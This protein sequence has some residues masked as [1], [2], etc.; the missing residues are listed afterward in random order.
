MALAL[1]QLYARSGWRA[2]AVFSGGNPSGIAPA[3]LVITRQ[4]GG[5]CAVSVLAARTIDGTALELVLSERL[6]SRVIYVL[7]WS[8]SSTP[9]SFV[10]PLAQDPSVQSP[11]DDPDAEAN[12]VDLAWISND[13][14]PSG[15]CDRRSGVACVQYD[16]L[17]RAELV[18]GELM[19]DVTAGANFG[20]LV[21][22]S[23][24]DSQ[25]MQAGAKLEAEYRRDQRVADASIN[26]AVGTSGQTFFGG[27]VQTRAGQQTPVRST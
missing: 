25:L 9:F 20:A 5:P 1:A 21:N 12:G 11:D 14:T 24:S 10:P 26:V 8:S 7:T 2:R 3:A 19:Q 4:D 6:L 27:Q 13:P 15:D 17:N 22:S 16:L 18:P 23:S